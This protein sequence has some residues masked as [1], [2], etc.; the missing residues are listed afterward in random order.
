MASDPNRY[1]RKGKKKDR[2]DKIN[3]DFAKRLAKENKR[4]ERLRKKKEKQEKKT[5]QRSLDRNHPLHPH[6][7]G[8]WTDWFRRKFR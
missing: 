2:H 5:L 6:R 4:R 7:K 8:K 3:D 1:Q